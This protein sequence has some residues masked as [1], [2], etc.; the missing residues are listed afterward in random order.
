MN[1]FVDA[2]IVQRLGPGSR[3][4][5]VVLIALYPCQLGIGLSR[6]GA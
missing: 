2:S 6:R 3:D 1:K 4:K 5:N